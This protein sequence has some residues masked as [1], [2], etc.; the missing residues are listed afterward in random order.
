MQTTSMKIRQLQT[1][2][3]RNSATILLGFMAI[4]PARPGNSGH[5][6]DDARRYRRVL[7][8]GSKR[9]WQQGNETRSFN[10]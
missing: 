6:A 3:Q 2:A 10:V 4:D 9:H 8:V 1:P 5:R 7:G